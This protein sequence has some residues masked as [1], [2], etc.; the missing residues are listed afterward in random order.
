M[1]AM[2]EGGHQQVEIAIA[3]NVGKHG[4]G[5]VELRESDTRC[6]GDLLE[7]PAPKVPIQRI[8]AGNGTEIEITQTVT[9]KVTCRH[10]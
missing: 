4:T 9:V 5:A 10:S 8:R 3:I 6:C 7:T 2:A 1:N